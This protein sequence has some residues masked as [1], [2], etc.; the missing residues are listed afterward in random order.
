MMKKDGLKRE[1]KG[2]IHFIE[3]NRS[4][5]DF[6]DAGSIGKR[7]AAQRTRCNHPVIMDTL[8]DTPITVRHIQE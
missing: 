2:D 8:K 3:R 6:D 7:Y 5:I 4:T 1:G